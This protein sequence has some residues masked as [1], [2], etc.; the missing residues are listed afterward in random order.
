M[1]KEKDSY[2]FIVL[3][4]G[5]LTVAFIVLIDVLIGVIK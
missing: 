4:A 2:L 1:G 5:M 3:I